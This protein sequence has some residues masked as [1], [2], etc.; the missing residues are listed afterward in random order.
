MARSLEA[1]AAVSGV[2]CGINIKRG[3]KFR[4]SFYV[5]R[6]YAQQKASRAKRLLI[7]LPAKAVLPLFKEGEF[8]C[9]D[10]QLLA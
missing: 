3:A 4:S 9:P 8:F 2:T 1:A 6:Q 10:G 7:S 5:N